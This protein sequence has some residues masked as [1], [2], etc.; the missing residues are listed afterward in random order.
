[1]LPSSL[2]KNW[3][4]LSKK[5]R[6]FIHVL[7]LVFFVLS[8]SIWGVSEIYLR[9]IEKQQEAQRSGASALQEAKEALLHYATTPPPV[10]R[11]E[12]AAGSY[13]TANI[14]FRRFALPCPD[15]IEGDNNLD[16]AADFTCGDDANPATAYRPLRSGSRFGRLPWRDDFANGVRG[17]GNRDFR[18]SHGERFWYILSNNVAD[19]NVSINPHS[20]LRLTSGW[21]SLMEDGELVSDRIAAIII[22]PGAAEGAVVSEDRLFNGATAASLVSSAHVDAFSDAY[23]DAAAY[24]Q[25]TT[26]ALLVST[27]TDNTLS[28]NSSA[29]DRLV[30]LTIDELAVG[31]GIDLIT[32]TD[33]DGR[34]IYAQLDSGD[35][36][37]GVSDL[38]Q[39]YLNRHGYLPEPAIFSEEA[40]TSRHR[41]FTSP[42]ATVAMG[43]F[44]VINYAG[45]P[46]RTQIPMEWPYN[47]TIQGGVTIAYGGVFTT[48][49]I[50]TVVLPP[51]ETTVIVIGGTPQTV[52]GYILSEVSYTEIPTLSVTVVSVVV[53]GALEFERQGGGGFGMQMQAN[54]YSVTLGSSDII[55]GSYISVASPAR[56]PSVLVPIAGLPPVYLVSSVTVSLSRSAQ[57]N[58]LPP[59]NVILA[60]LDT[61]LNEIPLD[62]A[63]VNA[64]SGAGHYPTDGLF[65]V[66]GS[67]ALSLF[68]SDD[69]N[70]APNLVINQ[71]APITLQS[72]GLFTVALAAPAYGYFQG[73]SLVGLVVYP[74]GNITSVPPYGARVLL[75]AGTQL[76]LDSQSVAINLPADYRVNGSFNPANGSYGLAPTNQPIIITPSDVNY[77]VEVPHE[78]PNHWPVVAG[79]FGFLPISRQAVNNVST[80]FGVLPGVGGAVSH[81]PVDIG[82]YTEVRLTLIPFPP[83]GRPGS[84]DI[85][86]VIL[87][88]TINLTPLTVSLQTVTQINTDIAA[89]ASPLFIPEYSEFSLPAG[90]RVLY[91]NGGIF[92][93]GVDFAFPQGAVSHLPPGAVINVVAPINAIMP[94]GRNINNAA[95]QTVEVVLH[96]GGML[97]LANARAVLKDGFASGTGQELFDIELRAEAAVVAG[98]ITVNTLPANAIL[99][100][101]TGRAID[102]VGPVAL[103]EDTLL[104]S[105]SRVRAGF[106]THERNAV[107]HYQNT[108]MMGNFGN[109]VMLTSLV[110]L[111]APAFINS[112]YFS[113]LSVQANFDENTSFWLSGGDLL[114]IS[115]G[116]NAADTSDRVGFVPQVILEASVAI[117]DSDIN[118][119]SDFSG[120]AGTVAAV[121]STTRITL[122]LLNSEQPSHPQ[123]IVASVIT[124]VAEISMA[125][126]NFTPPILNIT[127]ADNASPLVYLDDTT[128]GAGVLFHYFAGSAP[129]WPG[130]G[131]SNYRARIEVL[132]GITPNVGGS[133]IAQGTREISMALSADSSGGV[134]FSLYVPYFDPA[135]VGVVPLIES[136]GD[137]ARKNDFALFLDS[138]I[139][140][141][142][143][144]GSRVLEAG[145]VVDVANAF[146]WPPSGVQRLRRV[147][148][149]LQLVS[150]GEMQI[151][152]PDRTILRTDLDEVFIAESGGTPVVTKTSAPAGGV[153]LPY[154]QYPALGAD[155]ATATASYM[156]V[157]AFLN[158]PANAAII[159]PRGQPLDFLSEHSGVRYL[160]PDEP[161]G[162][163][164]PKLADYAHLPSGAV[165]IIPPG[166]TVVYAAAVTSSATN[167]VSN[168]F[169]TVS[170]DFI[171]T[172]SVTVSYQITVET[173]IAAT[174]VSL[175]GPLYL[176]LGGLSGG[177]AA[178][179]NHFTH[180]RSPPL[181][182]LSEA[183]NLVH[184][185]IT[186]S[187]QDNIYVRVPK[188][189][190]LDMLGYMETRAD[191]GIFFNM[192]PSN[193]AELLRDFPLGYAVA[194]ECRRQAVSSGAECGA[195]PGLSFQVPAGE[196]VVLSDGMS[197]PSGM[198]LTVVHSDVG[199]RVISQS[200]A[201]FVNGDPPAVTATVDAVLV[202]NNNGLV[203]F[204]GGGITPDI[205]DVLRIELVPHHSATA[206][207]AYLGNLSLSSLLND[208]IHYADIDGVLTVHVGGFI[209]DKYSAAAGAITLSNGFT[210]FLGVGAP[211]RGGVN[212]QKLF[213]KGSYANVALNGT[214]VELLMEDYSIVDALSYSAVGTLAMAATEVDAFGGVF[215]TL[216]PYDQVSVSG[217]GGAV[218]TGAVRTMPIETAANAFIEMDPGY[219]WQGYIPPGGTLTFSENTQISRYDGLSPNAYLR[220]QPTVRALNFFAT[221]LERPE[222]LDGRGPAAAAGITFNSP[223]QDLYAGLILGSVTTYREETQRVS[224]VFSGVRGLS[225]VTWPGPWFFTFLYPENTP[226][227]GAQLSGSSTVVLT[228]V[229]QTVNA[230]S[231]ITVYDATIPSP[232][233]TI[234][235]DIVT[236]YH[237]PALSITLIQT[238]DISNVIISVTIQST[239]MTVIPASTITFN[240]AAIGGKTEFTAGISRYI[241]SA[242]LE[243]VDTHPGG[244]ARAHVFITNTVFASASSQFTLYARVRDNAGMRTVT[245]TW[246]APPLVWNR[247]SN[248]FSATAYTSRFDYGVGYDLWALPDF[249]D[250]SGNSDPGYLDNFM[251]NGAAATAY[252]NPPPYQM[253]ASLI[254]PPAA[255]TINVAGAN[256]QGL[257]LALPI[258][259]IGGSISPAEQ[260]PPAYAPF[261]APPN[262]LT[263]STTLPISVNLAGAPKQ[264]VSYSDLV[265]YMDTSY[266]KNLGF[267]TVTAFVTNVVVIPHVTG[268]VT[269][270]VNIPLADLP[271]P[272]TLYF[273]D[274]FNIQG[275]GAIVP[276]FGGHDT[277]AVADV[278]ASRSKLFNDL[279]GYPALHAIYDEMTGDCVGTD[280]CAAMFNTSDWIPIVGGA[281][282]LGGVNVSV[283][284]ASSSSPRLIMPQPQALVEDKDGNTV[285]I[286]AGSM[287]LPTENLIYPAT[288]LDK[289]YVLQI[290]DGVAA[291]DVNPAASPRPVRITR[292]PYTTFQREVVLDEDFNFS[293][294][295][296]NTTTDCIVE[297]LFFD[298]SIIYNNFQFNEGVNVVSGTVTT[299]S[300]TAT[301]QLRNTVSEITRYDGGFTRG[302]LLN[303]QGASLVADY[304]GGKSIY[305]GEHGFSP[306]NL[307]N[308]LPRYNNDH[309]LGN[310]LSYHWTVPGTH[311]LPMG[312]QKDS[313]SVAFATSGLSVT[314]YGQFGGLRLAHRINIPRAAIPIRAY[315]GTLRYP[316]RTDNMFQFPSGS[317]A[318]AVNVD[319][320]SWESIHP[321]LG[322]RAKG[323]KIVVMTVATGVTTIVGSLTVG[324]YDDAYVTSDIGDKRLLH[325][326]RAESLP[327]D[328][329]FS[330]AEMYN[331]VWIRL[332]DGGQLV[333][334]DGD[335][336]YLA[337]DSI[338]N[339]L[340][341]TYLPGDIFTT[342]GGATEPR[343]QNDY[344]TRVV[345]NS[346]IEITRPAYVLPKGSRLVVA[347]VGARIEN[348]KAAVF[349]SLTPKDGVSCPYGDWRLGGEQQQRVTISQTREGVSENLYSAV[350]GGVIA[351]VGHPCTWFDD[352]EN[353]DGDRIFLYRGRRRNYVSDLRVREVSNDRTYTLG[354][355]LV[356]N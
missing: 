47:P 214:T 13:N 328:R 302:F 181:V 191:K 260:R 182:F 313:T 24:L 6:G 273:G 213:G 279:F 268:I 52:G 154:T 168:T 43:G 348:V 12:G 271:P 184:G 72:G 300:I 312:G 309:P 180:M 249:D 141:I 146:Y 187:F 355:Q 50:A 238:I 81:L 19:S 231:A 349:F 255:W 227:I 239:L 332:P 59:Y 327:G 84:L 266:N 267:R 304:Y 161:I 333:A 354:G 136:G 225:N 122:N 87:T 216:Y 210:L 222:G 169:V 286:Y 321:Y 164:F 118:E 305:T 58:A 176:G 144:S 75:P 53:T 124:A 192:V 322:L 96:H 174:L 208:D 64:L 18:G 5:Q 69:T 277:V 30:Y 56:L 175:A 45:G 33:S 3:P 172:V 1:M 17:I 218:L 156:T 356:L 275:P 303:E 111:A 241:L 201:E 11:A 197:A 137:R 331:N 61:G 215:S 104:R 291:I 48:V 226:I 258:D 334:A 185:N 115:R 165:A 171:S 148:D 114:R 31:T 245:A 283:A 132:S 262:Y 247:Y 163:A 51:G 65:G 252:F 15:V 121:I 149:D 205:G 196:E 242:T 34:N 71:V 259:G 103:E 325:Y 126:K 68:S 123:I 220:V 2:P 80:S 95:L 308:E 77:V 230:S 37:L 7:L 106:L 35:G 183:G 188:N 306:A 352:P 159:V 209:G 162:R 127:S 269:S 285:T 345:L 32:D 107:Y 143:I 55:A 244:F 41:L 112:V 203:S 272:Q 158:L 336:I 219:L 195:G 310:P 119:L 342:P 91:P 206:M 280:D 117:Y 134:P 27:R 97:G 199:L 320:G 341:G 73:D 314:T 253:A 22:A 66:Y 142:A 287:L 299:L 261:S 36:F 344:L 90:A 319:A 105:N 338:I 234:I 232:S 324:A 270:T 288:K 125:Y 8:V 190:R 316:D 10:I 330:A 42:T 14:P 256:Y 135:G 236:V 16:G 284:G 166:E 76:P 39:A 189:A 326:Q 250:L 88:N 85:S 339:P 317:Q 94:A 82:L 167:V 139:E 173:P 200:L 311:F 101:Y 276:P 26:S 109:P 257:T 62:N 157:H 207:R 83:P 160:S 29:A 108:L 102:N 63:A 346:T 248:P 343:L 70:V 49:V 202:N 329:V 21:L 198:L 54:F 28:A 282:A 100:P 347:N 211:L 229:R 193:Y 254:A 147:A 318:M 297:P 251:C 145:G 128:I 93:V 350:A 57:L 264:A 40:A 60:N 240:A 301:Y 116:V 74:D 337:P 38:L 246:N 237:D 204:S 223:P 99:Q 296:A 340:L 335:I 224:E 186:S 179:V 78:I 44:S 212:G 315:Q 289:D 298:K 353:M 194:P 79:D 92:N 131:R 177:R 323:L 25:L 294:V 98:G 113:T 170:I 295:T 46:S 243:L 86:L 89:V 120:A 233:G 4:L 140:A 217:V 129:L 133:L 278:Y 150:S 20:M 307:Y 351:N 274:D 130:E 292:A 178:F 110:G 23:L 67:S 152:L 138:D 9:A 221:G 153:I 281:I 228:M 155:N 235:M 293:P 290:V 151:H 263:I 265:F